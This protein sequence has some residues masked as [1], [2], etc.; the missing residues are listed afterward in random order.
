MGRFVLTVTSSE[1]EPV[2]RAS[3]ISGNET[4]E[5]GTVTGDGNGGYIVTVRN[6]SG[7]AL[8]H[9]GGPGTKLFTGTGLFLLAAAGLLQWIRRRK[10]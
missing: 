7:I 6:I 4:G 5:Q 10:I 9:T 8:P 2:I 3:W 1:T